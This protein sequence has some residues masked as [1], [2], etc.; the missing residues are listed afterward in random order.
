MSNKDAN[1]SWLDAVDI[2]GGHPALDCV[3]TVHSYA[4]P[5]QRDYLLSAAHPI[6][7][8]QYTDLIGDEQ[9][10]GLA[11]PARLGGRHAIERRTRSARDAKHCIAR[12]SAGPAKQT[13]IG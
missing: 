11:R 8:C 13:G 5:P 1:A 3:N 9:A 12:P 10:H 4:A 2:V 7:W 6:D